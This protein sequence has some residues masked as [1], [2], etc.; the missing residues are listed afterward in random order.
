MLNQLSLFFYEST[1]AVLKYNIVFRLTNLDFYSP[2][3]R[4]LHYMN[5]SVQDPDSILILSEVT[6]E[7]E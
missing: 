6:L 1:L 5:A 2:L 7:E 3:A 4:S